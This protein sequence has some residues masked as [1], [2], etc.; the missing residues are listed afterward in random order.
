M[1]GGKGVTRGYTY[2]GTTGH[3]RPKTPVNRLRRVVVV[4]YSRLEN[5]RD[6]R[7]DVPR[8]LDHRRTD[9]RCRRDSPSGGVSKS[10]TF[11]EGRESER[12]E[13]DDKHRDLRRDRGIPRDMRRV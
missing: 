7:R 1:G 10:K 13:Q 3:G 12:V 11:V 6:R 9:F 2:R 4:L 5:Q 8:T